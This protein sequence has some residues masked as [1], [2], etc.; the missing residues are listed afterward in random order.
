MAQNQPVKNC[1]I[2]AAPTG[3]NGLD[4]TAARPDEKHLSFGIWCDLYK[5]FRMACFVSTHIAGV[6]LVPYGWIW[7]IDDESYNMGGGAGR[8]M[9][10]VIWLIII[11]S[12]KRFAPFFSD[13]FSEVLTNDS[14]AVHRRDTNYD[15]VMEEITTNST[16]VSKRWYH[17]HVHARRAHDAG[18]PMWD[19]IWL[20]II[21]S[22]KRFAPFFSDYFSEV[23]TNDSSAVHR[24]DTNY[25]IVMEEITT[26]ST[27]VSK[28]WYHKH[29]H[30][31]R[32]HDAITTSV[33][34]QNDVATSFWRNNYVIIAL[35][36]RWVGLIIHFVV[37]VSGSCSFL[38]K[39]VIYLYW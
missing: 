35:C 3:F 9:W 36:V 18:R 12:D 1:H 33:L 7:T 14:S 31:R 38:N 28:R 20:I 23:L 29:V 15:I 10:D 37:T 19:V 39:S 13:Y 17:K 26:N 25:D 4:K 16:L 32:A 8:P 24:R 11:I 6:I 2:G 30:A 22:D 21:I 34:R 27:L 5:R